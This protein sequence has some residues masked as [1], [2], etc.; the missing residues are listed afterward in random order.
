MKKFMH[1]FSAILFAAITFSAQAQNQG[2]A[3]LSLGYNY[4]LPTGA[5]KSD[6]ISNGSARGFTGDLMFTINHKWSVGLGFGFQDYY[7]KYPR[8]IYPTGNHEETS[9]VLSNSI[10]ALPVIAKGTFMPLAGKAGLVQPYIT[11]GAGLSFVSF[12]QYLGAFGNVSSSASFAAQ[13][14]AGVIIPFKKNS[15]TGINIG[16]DYNYVRYQHFGYSNLN[17]LSFHAGVHF[18]LK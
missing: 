2:K 11:A 17:N 18:P 8:A 15:A 16:A 3:I 9:A 13:G 10:Q 5:F 7:Q 12:R 4:S 14:G 6:L 1:I